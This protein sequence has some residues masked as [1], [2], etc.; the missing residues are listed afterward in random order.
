VTARITLERFSA[1]EV[2]VTVTADIR[3]SGDLGSL[4]CPHDAPAEGGQQSG[5]ALQE[6]LT[7][8]QA[9]EVLNVSR[10]KVYGLIRTGQLRSIKIGKLRRISRQWIAEF[11]GRQGHGNR[12]SQ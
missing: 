2:R 3:I 1:G 10:D 9:A 12:S 8:E 6:F 4:L 7:V 11:A 5:A